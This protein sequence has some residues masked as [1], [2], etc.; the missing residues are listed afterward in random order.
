[1][2]LRQSFFVIIADNEP[3]HRV[4]IVFRLT[5]VAKILFVFSCF[6]NVG[7]KA[8]VNDIVITFG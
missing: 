5:A 7:V 3:L 2:V 8:F 1:M 4:A 6:V